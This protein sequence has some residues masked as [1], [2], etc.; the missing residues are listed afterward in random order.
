MLTTLLLLSACGGTPGKDDVAVDSGPVDTGTDADADTDVDA[1][2][3]A[4]AD[5]DTDTDTDSDSDSDSDTDTDSGDTQDTAAPDT[6]TDGDGPYRVTTRSS[7]VD[8]QDVTWYEPSGVDTSV[9]PQPVLIWAH[10]FGRTQEN[11][12]TGARRAAT[13]G[14]LVA[15]PELPS[16]YT[17]DHEGN[18]EWLATQMLPAA[19][20]A[21]GN[22]A[23]PAGY[24]GHSAGGLASLL[25]ASQ[26]EVDFLVTLD[27]VDASDLGVDADGLV[28]E[29]TLQLIGESS[30][31]NSSGNGRNWNTSGEQWQVDVTDATHCDFE[32]DTDWL[33]TSFCGSND[34]DRQA[35]V[36]IYAVAWALHHVGRGGSAYQPDGSATAADR[37]A[38]R[39]SD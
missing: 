36:N 28:D 12:A 25:A 20:D 21:V 3:D 18:A 32:S 2:T 34:A 7:R 31:C 35:L 17:G 5:T 26:S 39:I 11:Y 15:V 4:D 1:D 27:G 6:Y 13:W 30:S 10:G 8:G 22:D 24:V 19:R 37:S 16:V 23:A 29:P 14:F 9:G 38:G 33:C